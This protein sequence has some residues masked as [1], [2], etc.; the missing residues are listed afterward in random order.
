MSL[1]NNNREII[2]TQI[3]KKLY[4]LIYQGLES[5]YDEAV[6]I[7][8]VPKDTLRNFQIFLK[9]IPEWNPQIVDQEKRRIMLKLED[10]NTIE[11]LIKCYV[12]MSIIQLTGMNISSLLKFDQISEININTVLHNIYI[13][14]AR[15]LYSNP[16]L[17]YD[18]VSPIEQKK[19]Q[20]LVLEIIKKSI[21]DILLDIL[22]WEEISLRILELKEENFI[23]HTPQ[24]NNYMGQS[25]GGSKDPLEIVNNEVK[26]IVDKMIT[27]SKVNIDNVTSPQFI[28]TP[29]KN[30]KEIIGIIDNAMKKTSEQQ[31]NKSEDKQE[32][33]KHSEDKTKNES[34]SEDKP[35]KSEE[36]VIELG[37]GG[38]VV[39]GTREM[40]TTS[41]KNI[42][43]DL[44]DSDTSISHVPPSEEGFSGYADVFTNKNINTEEKTKKLTKNKFFS[45]YLKV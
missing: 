13:D 29:E 23:N 2:L 21:R 22:P 33:D 37:G 3:T 4:P 20:N 31:Q 6:K 45:N 30:K 40:D 9:K 38:S 7:S 35:H 34:K 36:K 39:K 10:P 15:E 17:M 16:F 18:K 41:I 19:N 14:I 12:K 25:G 11:L 5:I 8:E 27:P 28:D 44:Q 32:K 24:I 1:L 43:N 42:M 26:D